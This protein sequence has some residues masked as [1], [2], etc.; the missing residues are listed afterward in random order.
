MGNTSYQYH[1]IYQTENLI[2]G[3][4]YIGSHKTNDINDGYLGS[5]DRLKYAIRKYGKANFKRTVLFFLGTSEAMYAKERELVNEEFVKRDDTYNI[6]VGG[7]GGRTFLNGTY[8]HSKET[9]QK[10]R[11]AKIGM[12]SRWKNTYNVFNPT[13]GKTKRIPREEL[14]KWISDGWLRGTYFSEGVLKKLSD[15]SKAKVPFKHTEESRKKLSAA[16]KGKP[17]WNKGKKGCQVAWN[18]GLRKSKSNG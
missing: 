4:I 10:M 11:D 2:N 14:E 13:T 16:A 8:R 15:G 6:I 7:T 5:G 12:K 3:K 1:I 9:L 18:K 17:T